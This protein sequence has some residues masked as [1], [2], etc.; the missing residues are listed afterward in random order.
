[1][2][3]AEELHDESLNPLTNKKEIYDNWAST[4]DNYV[5]SLDYKGP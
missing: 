5:D 1:M 3:T 4:Y 2:K